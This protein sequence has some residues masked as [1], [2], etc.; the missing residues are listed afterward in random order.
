MRGA[1]QHPVIQISMLGI[2]IHAPHAGNDVTNTQVAV[3]GV[4]IQSTL[5]MRGATYVYFNIVTGKGISIHA[6]HAGSDLTEM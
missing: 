1:T 5:P 2:S 4:L 6:P 3:L